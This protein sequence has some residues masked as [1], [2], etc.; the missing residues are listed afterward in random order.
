MGDKYNGAPSNLR[1]F[2]SG[3]FNLQHESKIGRDNK[4]TT[5][6]A[7]AVFIVLYSFNFFL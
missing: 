6:F 1:S 4:K 5:S 7:D 2:F 3:F